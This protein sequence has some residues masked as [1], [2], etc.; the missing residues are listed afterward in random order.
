MLGAKLQNNARFPCIS[1][2]SAEKN[3]EMLGGLI[4]IPYFC[5]NYK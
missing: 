1:A 3:R 2:E 5:T 4:E